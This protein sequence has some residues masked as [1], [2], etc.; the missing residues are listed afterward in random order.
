[1]EKLGEEKEF[2][3]IE[4]ALLWGN[5]YNN[6]EKTFDSLVQAEYN[7]AVKSIEQMVERGIE[8]KIVENIMLIEVEC[9]IDNERID[10]KREIK[11]IKKGK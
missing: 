5:G 8:N 9:I 4:K 11:S 2:S 10:N 7:K 6:S 1:M 3:D